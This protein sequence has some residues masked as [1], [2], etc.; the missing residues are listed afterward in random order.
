MEK[1]PPKNRCP[2]VPVAP[3]AAPVA[4]AVLAVLAAPAV[5]LAASNRG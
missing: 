1:S 5:L 2:V 4:L 3:V